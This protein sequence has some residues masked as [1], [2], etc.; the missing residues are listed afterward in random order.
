MSNKLL[1]GRFIPGD[2]IVHRLDPRVKLL[3]SFYFVGIIFLADNWQTYLFLFLFTMV[4][5]LL[6]KIKLGFFIKGVRPLIW[7]ILFTVLLQMLFSSGGTVYWSW[8]PIVISSYGVVN[9]IYIFMRFVLIIFMST[10]LTLT[11]PPLSLADA[12]ESLLKP[13]KVIHFPVYEVALMLSIAL[14]FVPTLMDETEKIMN[15]QR[16]RGVDFGE[17][18]IFQ[19]MRA[20]VPLLIPLFVSSFNRAEDLATA[21]EARGYQGGEGRSKYR[22]LSWQ[23]ADNLTILA[24]ALVTVVLVILR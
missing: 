22:V 4:A 8:G 23:L 1:L 14:R 12:I 11:T 20:I 21:M 16:A 10:L 2:S 5:I 13:L 24:F 3:M 17:G 7:L 18:N 9:G 15:A 19:Q 6:T